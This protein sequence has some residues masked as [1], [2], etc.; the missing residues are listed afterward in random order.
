MPSKNIK[1]QAR[2]IQEIKSRDNSKFRSWSQALTG[3]GIK[4]EGLFLVH[5]EKLVIEALKNTAAKKQALLLPTGFK[6]SEKWLLLLGSQ[7]PVFSLAKPLFEELDIIGTDHPILVVSMMEIKKWN[8]TDPL[9][10][11][12]VLIP[13]SD[14]SNLGAVIRSATAFG[15]SKIVLLKEAAHPFHPKSLRA[16]AGTAMTAPLFSGPSI[17][18]VAAMKSYIYLDM[19]GKSLCD[20]Q[21]PK[22]ARLLLGEEGK[23]APPS[24]SGTPIQI[25]MDAK[26]ESLNASV[27]LGIALYD[28]KSKKIGSL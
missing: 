7:L 17:N 12:E 9:T 2:S 18:E 19:N 21:W 25:P 26:V 23:G 15:A 27:A 4:K 24:S 3:K 28:W 6:L 11:M 16:S 14:P 10:G 13:L 8:F 5:G 1:A 22:S 20:F